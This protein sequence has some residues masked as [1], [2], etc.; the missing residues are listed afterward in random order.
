M[1]DSLQGPAEPSKW[2][3][4][5]RVLMNHLNERF[6]PGSWWTTWMRDSQ[7]VLLNHLNER[8]LPG[9]CWTTLMK[10]SC[11]GPDEPS[12]W[13]SCQGPAEHPEWKILALFLLNP[14]IERFFLGSCWTIW[15]NTLK[16]L[17]FYCRAK[18]DKRTVNRI[19]ITA[20]PRE[21]SGKVTYFYIPTGLTKALTWS[22]M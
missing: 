7:Q 19:F 15:I 22:V 16:R 3:F 4:L 17:D 1:E 9:S 21:M 14:L 11:Q 2:K 13:D 18:Q 8:F 5:A 6:L 20:F 12:K 10:D